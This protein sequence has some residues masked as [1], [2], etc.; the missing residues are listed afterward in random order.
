M[1]VL[2][3]ITYALD[4]LPTDAARRRA[5]G[6]ACAYFGLAWC[7]ACDNLTPHKRDRYT[8]VYACLPC[9]EI[10]QLLMGDGRSRMTRPTGPR[11]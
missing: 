6:G 11:V 4:G 1:T 8:G 10:A 7:F 3:D 2:D 5:L 9:K